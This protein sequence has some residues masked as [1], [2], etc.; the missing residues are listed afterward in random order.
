MSHTDRTVLCIHGRER[1]PD[2]TFYATIDCRLALEAKVCHFFFYVVECHCELLSEV[3]FPQNAE[4]P[5]LLEL[6]RVV[7]GGL[8]VYSKKNMLV[9]TEAYAEAASAVPD[10]VAGV[11][12][13]PVGNRKRNAVEEH[14]TREVSVS[15]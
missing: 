10:V 6:G 14:I 4:S 15:L 13:H 1:A 3:G 7:D 8:G 12:V 11:V 5:C 2:G 9:S